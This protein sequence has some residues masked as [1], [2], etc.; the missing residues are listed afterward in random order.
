MCRAHSRRTHCERRVVVISY[1][2][3]VE[4]VGDLLRYEATIRAQFFGHTH[5]DQLQIFYDEDEDG[6]RGR[7]T[8]VAYVGPSVTT[9]QQ[10]NPGYR[11]YDVE[12]GG[13]DSERV[14]T[15]L[16]GSPCPAVTPPSPPSPLRPLRHPSV[17]P[18]SCLSPL[19]HPSVPSVTPPSP[20][21]PLRPLCHPSVL[22]VT[23]RL[24]CHPS[25]PYVTPPSPPSPLRP[26][27]H[28]FVS[29]VTPPSPPSPHHPLCHPCV[30][31]VT[32]LSP[33]SPLRPL[34][35]PSVPS[36]PS[37]TP[38]FLSSPLSPLRHPSIPSVTPPS[39]LHPLCHPSVTPTSPPS[40]LRPLRHPSVPSVT[41]LSPLCQ[42]SVPIVTSVTPLSPPSPLRHLITVTSHHITISSLY[43]VLTPP[44]WLDQCGTDLPSR[45][46]TT[47]T[48][49]PG[50]RTLL[51]VLRKLHFCYL[52]CFF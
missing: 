22:S 39:P 16:A 40:R 30:P 11:V 17:N 46:L 23:P 45:P 33:L 5:V 13:A 43:R 2:C 24:L 35:H 15:P 21:S 52:K 41:P 27:C 31:S 20:P 47:S 37:V 26:L 50:G 36:V 48:G 25:V 8:S 7:P 12:G 14:R 3:H 19:C 9:F 4:G 44:H 38:P 49:L 29:S 1:V 32:P 34:C 51:L 42:P 28:P 10:L 6:E 18:P